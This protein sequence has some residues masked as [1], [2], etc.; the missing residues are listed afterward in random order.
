MDLS[1]KVALVTGASRGIG[2]AIAL[3]LAKGGAAV[4]VNYSET[5][6]QDVLD[7]IVAGGGRAVAVQADVSRKAEVEAMVRTV[8]EQLG[9]LDV[10]VNNAG[11]CPFHEFLDMP[12]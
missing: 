7:E 5:Q 9:G 1:N 3:R 2:R 8:V 11:I 12:E 4:A 10:L 6:P